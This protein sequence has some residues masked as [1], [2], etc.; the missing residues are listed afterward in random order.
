MT[1]MCNANASQN[2][3][4][5][6]WLHQMHLGEYTTHIAGQRGQHLHGT[7]RNKKSSK[8][9]IKSDTDTQR[10]S[11]IDCCSHSLC[12]CQQTNVVLGIRTHFGQTDQIDAIF[13]NI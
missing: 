8:I 4:V 13:L 11:R 6:L 3:D 5:S 2:I 7:S 10:Q 9:K 12:I 1:H